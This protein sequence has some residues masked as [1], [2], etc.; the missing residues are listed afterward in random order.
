M[1]MAIFETVPTHRQPEDAMPTA[2]RPSP[3]ANLSRLRHGLV[4]WIWPLL[5]VFGLGRGHAVDMVA[6]TF[7]PVI[8]GGNNISDFA[9]DAVGNKYVI[10]YITTFGP[11]DFNPG[12]GVD[13]KSSIAD[14]DCYV[15]RFNAD[16]SYAWTQTFGGTGSAPGLGIA[17]SGTTVYATVYFSCLDAG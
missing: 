10:G 8:Q 3:S 16:G 12:V 17:V 13:L 15:S 7:P 5:L 9:V 1:L 2:A 11:I 4:K 14:Q 6:N